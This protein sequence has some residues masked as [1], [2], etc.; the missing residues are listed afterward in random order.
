MAFPPRFLCRVAHGVDILTGCGGRFFQSNMDA[1]A[2]AIDNQLRVERPAPLV[3]S[4][5]DKDCVEIF[6]KETRLGQMCTA[7]SNGR[8]QRGFVQS[9]H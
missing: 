5:T 6:F 8:A 3:I 4:G 9:G 1:R 7:F 2:Q